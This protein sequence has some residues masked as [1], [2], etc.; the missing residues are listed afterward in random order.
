MLKIG[1]IGCGYWGPN[2]IRDFSE[3]DEVEITALCDSSLDKL[4]RFKKK[5][6]NAQTSTSSEELFNSK[7]IDAIVVAT[8][9]ST[10]Y[11]LAK[12]A[13]MHGK[14]VLVEKPMTHNVDE[15]EELID[16]SKKQKRVL[17]VGHTFE[18]NPAVIRIKELIAQGE[19]GKIYYITSRRLNLGKIRDDINAL[20]NLAPHDISILNFIIDSMPLKVKAWGGS[21]LKDGHE[22]LAFINLTYPDNIIANVHVSWLD[23]LKVRDTVIVGSKKMVLYDDVDSEARI[24]I[25]DKGADKLGHHNTPGGFGEF[26]IKLRA[27]D[28]LVPKID[29]TAPLKE[30][31]RHFVYCVLNNKRPKT[32][33]ENGLKVVRV[34]NAANES[35]KNGGKEIEI[36]S[37]K[38]KATV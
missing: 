27:G 11:R 33:G 23:P 24:K 9:A 19:L 17:M 29:M 13:L 31:C 14:H 25:Y 32:D 22:D 3:I 38:E 21:F 15:A 5:F 28:L 7:N 10:H 20:W 16:L 8:P 26:Q 6:P 12:Q 36:A 2:L 35:L 34:L 30:E 18:F 4:S 37:R 1:I